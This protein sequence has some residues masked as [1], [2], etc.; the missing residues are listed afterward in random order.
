MHNKLQLYNKY[1]LITFKKE[2]SWPFELTYLST[3]WASLVVSEKRIC[4]HCLHWQLVLIA[5]PNLLL[6]ALIW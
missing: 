2:T 4:Y 5:L 6:W 1:W 3:A